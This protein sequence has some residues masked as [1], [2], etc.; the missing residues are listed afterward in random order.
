M[1]TSAVIRGESDRGG[2]TQR[3]LDGIERMGNKV[4]H[5]V[6]MFLYLIILVIVL[7]HAL[8]LLGVSVTE[9]IAEPVPITVQPDYYEDTAEPSLAI[10]AED[11]EFVISERTVAVRSLL[12][13]EG[14]RFMFTRFVANF[15]G[16]GAMAVTFIALLG[17]GVAEHA[18]M[19]A[20]LIRKLVQVAP[21][22]WFTFI[23]VFVGVLASIAADAGYL[24]LVPLGAAA[25]LS[26]GRHPLAGMAAAF[27]GVGGIFLV[28]LL[29]TP[30]DSMLNE[31]TNE[32]IAL[33]GGAPLAL[34][35][36]LY[37]AAASSVV[38]AVVATFVTERIVE[39]R[40]G[41][42][43]GDAADEAEDQDGAL[44][45][46]E[47]RGLKWALYGFL[48]VLALMLLITVPPGAPLRTPADADS[49]P[50]LDSLLFSI[51]LFFLV[52]GVCYGFGAGT[53]KTRNDVIHAGTK[54]LGSLGG[55]IFMFLLI[56]QFI[57]FFNYSNMPRVAAI[58][59]ADGL[60][61]MNIGALPLL[62]GMT[63]VIMLL[64]T[65]I[66][67]ALPKWAIFAP[68]FVPLFM[69]LGVAPQTVF[70][71]YRVGDSPVNIVTPLMVYLPFVVTIAQKYQKDAGIGTI[72][73]LM[74]PYT[75]MLSI[76]W[77]LFFMVWFWLGIPLGPGYPV[78][79]AP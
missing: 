51:F 43:H 78:A 3:L 57:A 47:S 40:L 12:T 72:V 37:F 36:N 50:F 41:A 65:I 34:T 32:A 76:T 77:I 48:V 60:E 31:V 54:T 8:Y 58:A 5:P 24:I 2:L 74:L 14:I 23:L 39:P 55:L 62:V 68:V 49:S 18:G 7:S 46:E 10:P 61:Q 17:A 63:V 66:P 64:D 21:R 38:M 27:G 35:A 11:Q 53:F 25:F 28:N 79:A 56:S 20:A 69:R 13:V 15:Q 52:S 6:L 30:T 22:R 29:I 73:A 67:G 71:A 4:P 19:M 42:Y 16:F 9:Q 70:A 59:M 33:V 75:L 45:P 44:S 1:A 26:L